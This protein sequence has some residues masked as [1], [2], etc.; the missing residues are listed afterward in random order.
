MF[1]IFKGLFSIL[2]PRHTK[3]R[4][5]INEVLDQSFIKQQAENGAIEFKKYADFVIDLMAKLAAPC[6]DEMIQNISQMTDTVR[7][8]YNIFQFY[9]RFRLPFHT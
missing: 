6:R 2:M 9:Y 5:M 4:E 8:S 1:K 7:I 3:I